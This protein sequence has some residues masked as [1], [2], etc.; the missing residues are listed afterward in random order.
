MI[1]ELH[2][3]N[4][5]IKKGGK[6]NRFSPQA[7]TSQKKRERYRV[8]G[9]LARIFTR[10]DQK[11]YLRFHP[12]IFQGEKDFEFGSAQR[13]S[14]IENDIIQEISSS[15][16]PKFN[17]ALIEKNGFLM[18][19]EEFEVLQEIQTSLRNQFNPTQVRLIGR[20]VNE[21]AITVL[22]HHGIGLFYPVYRNRIFQLELSQLYDLGVKNVE[23]PITIT[24][25][26]ALHIL[27]MN[28]L[29]L[30]S[31]PEY[32]GE[33]KSLRILELRYN[34]LNQLPMSL[35]KLSALKYL[36]LRNNPLK[37]DKNLRTLLVELVKNG[38]NVKY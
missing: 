3:L 5:W 20:K 1:K 4:N 26:K 36:D 14:F 13:I 18:P 29:R 31:I 7:T 37:S 24:K 30:E 33:L 15:E 8:V 12:Q 28:S 35:T 2:S 17:S 22:G 25:L 11:H 10:L 6:I 21:F 9:L 32:I 34:K 27:L 23:I 16:I 19:E 38:V